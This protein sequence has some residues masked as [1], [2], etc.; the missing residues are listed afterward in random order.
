[1]RFVLASGSPRRRELLET[2]GVD[3]DEVSPAG[4][5]EIRSED[6]TPTEYSLRLAEEKA[7]AVSKKGTQVLAADTIVAIDNLIFEKPTSSVENIEMLTTL[8]R[9]W[10]QV[11]TAWCI[12]SWPDHGKPHKESGLCTTLVKFRILEESEIISY[13]ATGEGKDKAGGYGIQGKGAALISTI[14]GSYSNV[15]GLPMEMIMPMLKKRG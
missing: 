5:A 9:D 12:I 2:C 13:V 4:I 7:A 11:I 14:E 1:M 3:I 6:E 8:S 10:H 15:V